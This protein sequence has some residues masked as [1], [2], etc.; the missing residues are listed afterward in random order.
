LQ[1]RAGGW[2]CPIWAARQQDGNEG[3]AAESTP[4]QTGHLPSGRVA[5]HS[6]DITRTG[7]A[8]IAKPIAAARLSNDA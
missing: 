6:A 3:E 7:M 2:C 1:V 5:R 4:S 8:E